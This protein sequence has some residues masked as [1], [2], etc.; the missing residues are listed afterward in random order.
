MQDGCTQRL[1]DGAIFLVQILLLL[2]QVVKGDHPVMSGIINS[3][4]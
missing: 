1:K 4:W 2:Y 3:Q